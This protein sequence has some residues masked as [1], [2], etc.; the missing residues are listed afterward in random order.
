MTCIATFARETNICVVAEGVETSEE[1]DALV[2]Y[3]IE[4][5][6]GFYFD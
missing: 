2:S 4:L 6:Q 3:G 5:G 1:S